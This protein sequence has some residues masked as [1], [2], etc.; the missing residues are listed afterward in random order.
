MEFIESMNQLSSIVGGLGKQLGSMSRNIGELDKA[1]KTLKNTQNT[2]N[3][4]LSAT[5]KTIREAQPLTTGNRD[6][7]QHCNR[8][9]ILHLFLPQTAQIS[10][11]IVII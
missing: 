5:Y 2:F 6:P 11:M 9:C 7:K 8:F 10:N 3:A 4:A 1:T